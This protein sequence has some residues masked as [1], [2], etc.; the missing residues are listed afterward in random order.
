MRI[1][2]VLLLATGF[3]LAKSQST[4]ETADF[5]VTDA[6]LDLGVNV[7][8]LPGLASL[9]Q[10]SSLAGCSIACNSLR[11]L[12]NSQVIQQSTAAYENFTGSYWSQ[13][14]EQVDPYCIFTPTQAEQVS[15]QV[16]LSRL[17]QCP[18][19]IK[20]GG[21]A[22]F[23]GASSI[24]GGITL[25]LQ[26]FNQIT[27]SADKT[28]ALLGPGNRWHDVYVALQ[29]Q[30]IEVIGGRVSAIGVGGLTLG[31]G[32]S[33]FSNLYGWACDNVIEYEVVTASGI[34]LTVNLQTFPDLYWALRGGGNNFG[35]VTSFKVNTI[36][37]PQG[38][39]WGGSRVSLNTSGEFP[40]L[41]KAFYDLGTT[42][43]T[44]DPNAAQILSFTSYQGLNLAS[45][46]LE[47]AKP[48]ANPPIF[49]EYFAVPTISDTTS[50]R[51]LASIT[52]EFA[53][54][55]PDG[56]R[57]Q[58]WA[59]AYK[60]TVD[61]TT[62]VTNVFYE[63]LPTVVNASG[64]VPAAT[65]QVITKP[66]IAAMQKNGGNALGLTTDEGPLLLLNMNVQWA[67]ASDDARITAFNNRIIQRTVAYA[68]QNGLY[69]EYLYMNYASQYQDVIASYGATN[70][71]R[72]ISIAKKYDPTSVFQTLNPGYFKLA[73][74]PA[75]GP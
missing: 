50:V 30:N 22:A 41:I 51:T 18:F 25:S 36:S 56:S 8:A 38:M 1:A 71:A 59:V 32:I 62:F 15:V 24:E 72:L 64:I 13:Q 70:K 55:N 33:F 68:K 42:G 19:A 53:A 11:L 37:L 40:Q 75:S 52:D 27:P 28:S 46:A 69:N 12:F 14:Q 3:C 48:V 73:G 67:S 4:L 47:Y 60:L 58:Y 44:T 31:G 26:N 61:M 5:N 17:T 45:A 39:M 57:E 7:T 23:A 6:L 66:Q 2:Q 34:V 65:L 9:A 49:N 43:A 10:R 74:P 20:S 35:I 16:L 54:S 21:H 63:E 29:P